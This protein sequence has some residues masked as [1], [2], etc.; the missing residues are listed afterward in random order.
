MVLK[1]RRELTMTTLQ[2]VNSGHPSARGSGPTTPG[3]AV[4]GWLVLCFAIIPL[5]MAVHGDGHAYTNLGLGLLLTGGALVAMARLGRSRG[6]KTGP[7][8]SV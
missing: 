4:A 5:S 6:T 1:H 7:T 2:T 8:G 3:M